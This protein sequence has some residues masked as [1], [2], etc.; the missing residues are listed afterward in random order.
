LDEVLV[1]SLSLVWFL[2]LQ[3]VDLNQYRLPPK[4]QRWYQ[5]CGGARVVHGGGIRRQRSKHLMEI[6]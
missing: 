2:F 1:V 6:C 5:H 3:I 4:V